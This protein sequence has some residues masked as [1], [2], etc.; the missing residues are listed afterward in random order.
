MPY[1]MGYPGVHHEMPHVANHWGVYPM[2]CPMVHT[3][4]KTSAYLVE[5]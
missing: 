1:R 5:S 4:M 3:V 2:G